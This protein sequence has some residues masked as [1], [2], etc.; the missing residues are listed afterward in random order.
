MQGVRNPCPRV[1]HP[2]WVKRLLT[3]K[4]S[5]IKQM[6]IKTMFGQA[7]AATKAAVPR[8]LHAVAISPQGV[9]QS[10]ET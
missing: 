8:K 7:A 9:S 3:D 5:S 10:G 2:V 6:S 1:E 4:F